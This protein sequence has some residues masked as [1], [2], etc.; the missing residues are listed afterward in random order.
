MIEQMLTTHSLLVDIFL[1]LLVLGILIPFVTSENSLGF[2]KASFIYTMTFQAIASMVA[3]TGVIAV[4]SGDLGWEPTTILMFG[5]WA[6]MMMI[7]IKKYK[8]IKL[9]NLENIVTYQVLKVGFIKIS[10]VQIFLVVIMMA[11]MIL[12]AKDILPF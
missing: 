4:F 3:F 6:A 7:E 5:I 2:R 12:Q 8:A 11:I 1:G 9:A 10:L